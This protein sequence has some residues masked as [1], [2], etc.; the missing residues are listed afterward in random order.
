M[1]AAS[2]NELDIDRF[3]RREQAAA[4]LKNAH[5]TILSNFGL[6]LT[7]VIILY[8]CNEIF[9]PTLW[10]LAIGCIT[11]LRLLTHRRIQKSRLTEQDPERVLRILT[12]LAVLSGVAWCPVPL[13]Y[14]S[15]EA[16]ASGAFIIFIMV[17]MVTGAVIQSVAASRVAAAYG[18]P[19]I[20]ATLVKLL[21]SG[22][23]A[24]YIIA[25]DIVFL[26][27]MLA[28][29]AKLG[30][31]GFIDM[32]RA[33]AKATILARSLA[34][35]NA[36]VTESNRALTVQ[37]HTD[38]LTSLANRVGFEREAGAACVAGEPVALV[39]LDVDNFKAVNDTR[40]HLVGDA[41]LQR[42]AGNL[43][44]LAAAPDLVARLGGD[45]FV[46]LFRNGDVAN[47]ARRLADT[48]LERS[49]APMSIDGRMLVSTCSIGVAVHP[50]GISKFDDLLAQA[51][52]ALYRA[53]DDG[54]ACVRFFDGNMQRRLALLRC[55]DLDLPDA[56]GSGALYVEF[57][58]QLALV[59]RKVIGFEMLLRWRHPHVGNIAP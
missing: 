44:D 17:G 12:G 54:R 16:S 3:V 41:V 38:H 11:L 22:S 43:A 29:A 9:L 18:T 5:V 51:D 19:T 45:E 35:A 4:S 26:S 50:D 6:S 30:Q 20:C 52:L 14:G 8:I 48:M 55:I 47:R 2:S 13:L 27:I 37:A 36:A 32:Q 42:I 23:T 39:I 49:R 1:A 15:I 53:K 33:V 7:T 25:A 10:V 34:E 56:L 58:P 24:G 28:R 21:L 40:G 31:G 57:Q 46:V 59:D